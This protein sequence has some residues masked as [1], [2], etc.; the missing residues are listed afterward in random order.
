MYK[1]DAYSDCMVQV[2]FA[3]PVGYVE[4]SRQKTTPAPSMVSN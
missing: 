1:D 2:D 4:P 3:P